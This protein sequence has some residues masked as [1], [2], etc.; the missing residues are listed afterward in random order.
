MNNTINLKKSQLD[1]IN[2]GIIDL[3]S[4]KGL[5]IK[6]DTPFTCFFQDTTDVTNIRNHYISQYNIELPEFNFDPDEH[7]IAISIGRK[8]ID[9]MKCSNVM[10]QS[11]Q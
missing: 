10:I 7:Y 8:I 2:E 6:Q 9:I 4:C 11:Q 3:S 1:L 5:D